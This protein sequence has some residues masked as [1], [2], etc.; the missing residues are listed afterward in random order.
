MIALTT[1]II[2]LNVQIL[3]LICQHVIVLMVILIIKQ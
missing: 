1:L 3:E 2:V